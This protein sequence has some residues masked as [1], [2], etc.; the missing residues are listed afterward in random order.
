M[1]TTKRAKPIDKSATDIDKIFSVCQRERDTKT[2]HASLVASAIREAATELQF[3]WS[4]A[5]KEWT[6]ACPHCHLVV[7]ISQQAYGASIGTRAGSCSAARLIQRRVDRV[8]SERERR[9]DQEE[10]GSR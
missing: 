3:T 2:A 10:G 1:T 9:R 5:A 6:R 7:V 8:V 4:P